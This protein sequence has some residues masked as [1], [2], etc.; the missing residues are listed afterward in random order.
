[1]QHQRRRGTVLAL[2]ALGLAAL[3]ICLGA[4]IDVGRMSLAR[5]RL[6]TSCDF[7]A[8]AGGAYAHDQDQHKAWDEAAAVYAANVSKGNVDSDITPELI[9]YVDTADIPGS[10]DGACYRIGPDVVTILHPY[11]DAYTDDHGWEPLSLVCVKARRNIRLPFMSA[12]GLSESKVVARAVAYLGG[13]TLP[14]IFARY[15]DDDEWGLKWSGSGGEVDGDVHSN[16]KVWFTG[17]NHHITGLTEYR[18][19]FRETGS[20][21]QFDGGVVEG[22]IEEYPLDKTWDDLAPDSYDYVYDDYHVLAGSVVPPGTYH[23]LG[24]LRMSGSSI[25]ADN[26]LFMVEGDVHISGSGYSME[27]TT[28]VAR[29]EIDFSGSGFRFS[30]WD[31]QIAFMSLSDDDRAIDYSG[32]DQTI[33]GALF[34][35]NGGIEFSGSGQCIQDGSLI[36]QYIDISGSGFTIN[37]TAGGSA[38]HVKL[39]R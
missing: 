38:Q 1:M 39:V 14:A 20:G 19:R 6:Q 23:I 7:A 18:H 12:V 32:S 28:I 37:G 31:E 34:A 33:H 22:S 15:E 21:H 3:V 35:P 8:L 4:T 26:C 30:S 11:R 25:V 36:A 17:S 5:S 13:G 10:P 16:T 2:F 24:D 27:H 9:E 29:G